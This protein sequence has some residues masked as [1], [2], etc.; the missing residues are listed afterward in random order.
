M[1]DSILSAGSTQLANSSFC[2]PFM[3]IFEFV[4]LAFAF[5][6]LSL[7]CSGEPTYYIWAGVQA[8]C[9]EQVYAAVLMEAPWPMFV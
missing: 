2:I 8:A 3:C 7:C 4:S 9:V 6:L 5:I 1:K